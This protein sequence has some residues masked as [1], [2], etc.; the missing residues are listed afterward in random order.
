[1]TQEE[2]SE[3][4]LDALFIGTNGDTIIGEI[5][6]GTILAAITNGGET[7]TADL[8]IRIPPHFKKRM[9]ALELEVV[10]IKVFASTE[11][12]KGGAT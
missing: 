6:A 7:P 11:A 10:F 8:V 9:D 4:W 12:T 2:E 3:M 1:M 5:S